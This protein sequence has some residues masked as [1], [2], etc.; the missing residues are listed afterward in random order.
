MRRMKLPRNKT[1]GLFCLKE[2]IF[3]CANSR[4]IIIQEEKQL[5]ENL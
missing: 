1:F 5:K 4:E 2:K 3:A